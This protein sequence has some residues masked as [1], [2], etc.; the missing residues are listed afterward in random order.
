MHDTD[1][2]YQI[3]CAPNSDMSE[4]DMIDNIRPLI[5]KISELIPICCYS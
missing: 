4:L 5:T 3:I 1:N 2:L